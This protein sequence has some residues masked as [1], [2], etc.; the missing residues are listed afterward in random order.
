MSIFLFKDLPEVDKA[1]LLRGFCPWCVVKV[2]P[3]EDMEN[4][5][6][7]ECLDIYIT[8]QRDFKSKARGK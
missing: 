6:C 5:Q 2:V 8:T 4:D 1:S 3:T 7:P